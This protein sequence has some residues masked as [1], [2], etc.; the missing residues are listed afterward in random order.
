MNRNQKLKLN[1]SASLINRIIL[2]ISGLILPRFILS[3]YG[4]NTNG[5]VSSINQFLSVITF[6]DLGVG[7]VVQS[8]L[9]KPLATG[10]TERI[11][12]TLTSA[13]N[14]FRKIAYVLVVYVVLLMLLYPTLINQNV[15]YITTTFLIFAVSINLFAQYFFGIISEIL[16]DADQRSYIQL[17]VESIVVIINLIISIILITHGFSIQTVKLVSSIFLVIRPIYLTYYVSKHYDI[18]KN[19]P[20]EEE[21]LK[22]KWN[23]MAQHI[24]YTVQNSVDIIILTLFSTLKDVSIYSVYNLV[25]MGIRLLIASA[26]NNFKAYFGN[27]LATETPKTAEKLFAFMEWLVH[28]LVTLLYGITIVLIVPFV[29]LYTSGVNDVNYRQPL[30]GFLNVVADLMYS[31]RSPYQSLIFAAGHFKQTQLSSIIEVLI[32]LVF[33]SIFVFKFGLIGVAIGTIFSMS[34]RTI[35]L[36]FYL[37]KNIIYRPISH[38]I[39]HLLVDAINLTLIVFLGNML[40]NYFA[41]E[42]IM[43]WIMIALMITAISGIILLIS[44]LIF[45]RNNVY[46]LLGRLRKNNL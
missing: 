37:R 41:V 8:A 15:D 34:Y 33:S 10:D 31:L 4:S 24:A 16:L 2:I 44:N 1:T 28:N 14:Y 9:Y 19:V 26:T 5:L 21:P 46:S 20:Y 32:N 35:Y 39:K 11:N 43:D 13:K 25:V 3:Y 27:I 42:S 36:A 22:Q 40:M 45:Y 38:F 12:I 17:N 7:T 18:K 23:G 30:F 6:L 29:I